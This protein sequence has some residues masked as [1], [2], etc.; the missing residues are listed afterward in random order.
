MSLPINSQTKSG[1]P[2]I[3]PE[4]PGPPAFVQS[5]WKI[6][7]EVSGPDLP[8]F[9]RT[10]WETLQAKGATKVGEIDR[11]S[12]DALIAE[13][14]DVV[15]AR[16]GLP[17]DLGKVQFATVDRSTAAEK[18]ERDTITRFGAR[19]SHGLGDRITAEARRIGLKGS[20]TA[21][22][23][24][25]EG[26]IA[27]VPENA[28][29]ASVDG[30]R[31]ALFGALFDAARHQRYPEHDASIQ[32]AAKDMHAAAKEHGEG[33]AAHLDARDTFNAR[34]GWYDAHGLHEQ[35]RFLKSLPDAQLGVGLGAKLSGLV[36]L[37]GRDGRERV[38]QMIF[39]NAALEGF[40]NRAELADS[41]Y[42]KPELIDVMLKSRGTLD[43]VVP[44]DMTEAAM[45]KL[46]GAVGQMRAQ[47]GTT[48]K[49]Q[50]RLVTEG[51]R[52]LELAE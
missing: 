10:D 32:K 9:G 27:I 26:T 7:G 38:K 42:K 28:K 44:E 51:G 29:N 35:R 47:A 17:L 6:K 3:T 49:L 14:A 18:V 25:S 20:L 33:S 2:T 45:I 40:T 15:T 30:L 19:T 13:V 12:L 24:P 46:F 41:L 1:L 36:S 21:S 52:E 31:V 5:G 50:I 4:V 22:F 11:R 39:A 16:T 48:G 23:L 43:L 8:G 34:A 37:L